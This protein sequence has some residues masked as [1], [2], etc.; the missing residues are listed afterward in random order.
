MGLSRFITT[1][2]IQNTET[3][4]A[5]FILRKVR[6]A[7]VYQHGSFARGQHTLPPDPRPEVKW[8]TTQNELN[9]NEGQE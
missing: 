4:E 5:P 9:A 6:R 3:K 7:V 2:G 1:R 8:R